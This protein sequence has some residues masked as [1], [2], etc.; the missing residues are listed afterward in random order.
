MV[1][2][3]PDQ[4]VLSEAVFPEQ[5]VAAL[6]VSTGSPMMYANGEYTPGQVV[7]I[8]PD[9]APVVVASGDTH[10]AGGGTEP[11]IRDIAHSMVPAGKSVAR[12]YVFVMVPVG[13]P[14]VG[15]M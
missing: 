4:V 11:R 3:P 2:E 6:V 10:A 13:L 12:S 15:C 9:A 14:P 5:M 8:D 1:P 7:V